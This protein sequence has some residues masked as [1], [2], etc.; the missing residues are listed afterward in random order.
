MVLNAYCLFSWV[1]PAPIHCKNKRSSP[2]GPAAST[3]SNSGHARTGARA[4]WTAVRPHRGRTSPCGTGL[5]VRRARCPFV[6][7]EAAGTGTASPHL[8]GR[9]TR[10]GR[11]GRD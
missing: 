4:G 6:C 8:S 2:P 7:N 9:P 5:L 3:V 1:L 11:D 10:S